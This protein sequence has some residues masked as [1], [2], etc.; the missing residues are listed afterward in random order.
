MGVKIIKLKGKKTNYIPVEFDEFD[1]EEELVVDSE[2]G[3]GFVHY[4]SEDEDEELA[5]NKCKDR[6]EVNGC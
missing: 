4:L 1:F 5:G 6:A 2:K 3:D